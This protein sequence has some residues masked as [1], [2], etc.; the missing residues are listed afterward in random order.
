MN[1][2]NR[3]KLKISRGEYEFTRHCLFDKLPIYDFTSDDV[4][5]AVSTCE[6]ILKQ[7]DDIRGT[8]YVIFGYA[9]NGAKVEIVCRFT[10]N[11]V[12]FVTIYD[13]E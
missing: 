3:I 7:T 12:L 9:L 13:Y 10:N 4:L 8:R 6:K 1:D 11:K 5:N 2:L